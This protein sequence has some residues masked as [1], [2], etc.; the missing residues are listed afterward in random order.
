MNSVNEDTCREKIEEIKKLVVAFED[1]SL[2]PSTF[3]HCDHLAVALWYEVNN[4]DGGPSMQFRTS[5]LQFVEHHQIKAYNETITLFWIKLVHYH[6][7][8]RSAGESFAEI[9]ADLIHQYGDSRFIY[10][11]YSKDY[12]MSDEAKRGWKEPD[13]RALEFFPYEKKA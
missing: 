1:C 6:F 7:R 12:L 2:D 11:Y 8:Q 13:L 4:P 5:L 10:N 9:L 3:K